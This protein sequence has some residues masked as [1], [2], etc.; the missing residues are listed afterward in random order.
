[1]PFDPDTYRRS[2]DAYNKWVRAVDEPLY[3]LC[4][5]HPDH[6]DCAG[7]AAKCWTIGRTYATGIERQIEGDG[8]QGGSMKRLVLRL[9][10]HGRRVDALFGR[11]RPLKTPLSVASLRTVVDVHGQFLAILSGVVRHDE[12]PRAFASKYLH[13]HCPL[14]PIYDSVAAGV[15]PSQVRWRDNLIVFPQSPAA[16]ECYTHF[17]FRFWSLYE[18]ARQVVGREAT[19][20]LL[21]YYLLYL[22]GGP[23]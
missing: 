17:C 13:F 1:V 23:A 14:V 4:R 8:K 9:L 10:E 18:Q 21:D 20:K 6:A 7:V 19:V 22:G 16:D 15:I 11:L 2:V 5:R 3:E 12:T